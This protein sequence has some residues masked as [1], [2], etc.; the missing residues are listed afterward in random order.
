MNAQMSIS[1]SAPKSFA[2]VTVFDGLLFLDQHL[3]PV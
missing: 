3:G 1:K 2:K